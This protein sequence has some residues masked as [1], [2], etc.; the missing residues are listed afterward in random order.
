MAEFQITESCYLLPTPAGAYYAT[1]DSNDEPARRLLMALI[2]AEQ[3]A[4]L[5]VPQLSKWTGIRNQDDVLELLY[6]L[7]KLG[8]IQGEENPRQAP[9]GTL[10][11]TLPEMIADFSSNGKV[12]LADNMGFYLASHGF[13]HE[14]AEELSALSADLSSL[15]KRHQGLLKNNLGQNSS[16]WAIVD[17]AGNGQLGFWPLHVGRQRFVLILS[18]VVQLNQFNF[19]NMIWALSKRYN[20]TNHLNVSRFQQETG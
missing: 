5:S 10:E 11:S 20:I 12:L 9:A 17:A 2:S 13:S 19:V 15:Y 6:R 14:T 1:A 18:G 8:W 16:A 7:Q 4:L 3:S